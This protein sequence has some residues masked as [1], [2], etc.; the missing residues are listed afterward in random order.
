MAEK[1]RIIAKDTGLGNQIQFIPF[2]KKMQEDSWVVTDSEVYNQLGVNVP[3][4]TK[5]K[6]DIN[7]VL[8]LYPWNLV[9]KTKLSYF[10]KGKLYGFKYKVNRKP[11]GWLLNKALLLDMSV[12]EVINNERL[13]GIK[14]DEFS[15]PGW[16]PEPRTIAIGVSNKWGKNYKYWEELGLLLKAE[17][18]NVKLFGDYGT[19]SFPKQSTPTIKDLYE[20]LCKCEYY[21]GTDNGIT[22]LADILG[23]SGLVLFGNTPITKNKPFNDRIKVI[24]KNLDCAPCYKIKKR[25]DQEIIYNCL[26][27][28]PREILD[29]FFKVVS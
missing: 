7:Y 6:V 28:P 1:I 14:I 16:D 19:N 20:Q 29:E 9:V 2:I 3:I 13:T 5:S 18:Y 25:C 21:I 10:G 4:D 23:L 11:V 24:S 17:G 15:L 8:C 26:E 12:S 27:I 22:H